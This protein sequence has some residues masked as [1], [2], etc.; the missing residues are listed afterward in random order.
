MVKQKLAMKKP[1]K[2]Y[3]IKTDGSS[4]V[5][6][7]GGPL[8]GAWLRNYPPMQQNFSAFGANYVL[9]PNAVLDP[10]F[11]EDRQVGFMFVGYDRELEVIGL[12]EMQDELAS[13]GFEK[14]MA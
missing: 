9:T 1:A 7:T 2:P 12:T 8:D 10:E 13:P 6:L 3:L 4:Y 5:R 14:G 11:P